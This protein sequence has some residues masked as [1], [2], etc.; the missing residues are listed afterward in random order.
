M[1]VVIMVGTIVVPTLV[2]VVVEGTAP[3][4]VTVTGLEGPGVY[5]APLPVV[6]TVPVGLYIDPDGVGW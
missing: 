4:I 6:P 5:E 2:T 1:K 3:V